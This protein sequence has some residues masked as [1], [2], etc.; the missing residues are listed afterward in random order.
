MARSQPRP[1]PASE[2]EIGFKRKGMVHWLAPWFLVGAGHEVEE[3]G[4]FARYTDKREVEAGLPTALY[5]PRDVETSDAVLPPYD[6]ASYRDENGDLWID[7]ASDVGEGFSPTYTVAWLLSRPRLKLTHGEVRTRRSADGSSCSGVTRSTR[8][9][10]GTSTGIDSSARIPRHSPGWRS[11][12]GA[13]PL[14]D[15]R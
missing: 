8:P 10:A 13:A 1:R 7:F 6:D 15:P 4:R 2:A 11:G 14:R 12:E 5:E 9:R 3:S